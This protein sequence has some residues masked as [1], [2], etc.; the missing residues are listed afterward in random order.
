[1]CESVCVLYNPKAG[2]GHGED[3]VHKLDAVLSDSQL[4]YQDI[5]SVDDYFDFFNAMAPGL[6]V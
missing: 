5:T 2:N 1:M 6:R 4:R 3:A